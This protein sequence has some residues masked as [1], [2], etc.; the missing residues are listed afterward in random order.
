M[1]VGAKFADI[2]KI[3]ETIRGQFNIRKDSPCGRISF[4]FMVVETE[5]RRRGWYF[6]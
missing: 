4:I 1:L 5:E 2:V 6:I 3:G